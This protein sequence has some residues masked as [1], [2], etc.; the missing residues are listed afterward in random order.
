MIGKIV[1]HYKILEKLGENGD[2][3]NWGKFSAYQKFC[4]ILYGRYAIPAET[5]K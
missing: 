2:S 3:P 4:R 1:S 5:V